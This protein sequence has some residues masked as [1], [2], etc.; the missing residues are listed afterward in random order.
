MMAMKILHDYAPGLM[1]GPQGDWNQPRR[2][3]RSLGSLTAT[4][5]RERRHVDQTSQERRNHSRHSTEL[6]ESELP[7]R[8]P[9][10]KYNLNRAAVRKWRSSFNSSRRPLSFLICRK[11]SRLLPPP[12]CMSISQNRCL[13]GA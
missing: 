3:P 5:N 9:A 11:S 2:V 10:A 1:E 12:F 13:P 8:T 6:R 7:I 4:Q